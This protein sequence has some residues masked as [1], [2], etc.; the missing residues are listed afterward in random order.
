MIKSRFSQHQQV[1]SLGRMRRV[2]G[3]SV[4]ELVAFIILASIVYAGAVNRFSQFPGQAERANFLAIS[5]TLQ[6]AINT[7]MLYGVGVGRINSPQRLVGANPM[8]LMLE[9]P[10]NYLGAF[11]QLD[12]SNLER[13]VWYFDLSTRELVYLV[14]DTSGVFLIINGTAVPT[15][16]IRFRMQATYSMHEAGSGIPVQALVNNG[17][18][19]GAQQQGFDGIALR[20][21]VPYVW[22]QANPQDLI[23]QAIAQ[24]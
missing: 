3:F 20:P 16:E 1:S 12:T 18:P 5:T 21:T 2:A 15:N 10:S 8:D 19:V 17:A 24:N 7:E 22:N 13:R 14:N 6:S 11:N 9:P 4:F 23:D